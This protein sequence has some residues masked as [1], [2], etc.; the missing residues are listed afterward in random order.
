MKMTVKGAHLNNAAEMDELIAAIPHGEQLRYAL[1]KL[2]PGI[3]WGYQ[4][5]TRTGVYILTDSTW[6]VY[7]TVTDITSAQAMAVGDECNALPRWGVAEFKGAARRAVQ[8]PH[9][10]PPLGERLTIVKA[11]RDSASAMEKMRAKI[12][13]S[14]SRMM[15]DFKCGIAGDYDDELRV[16]WF[17]GA[18]FDGVTCISI[19]DLSNDEF[20]AFR[21]ELRSMEDRNNEPDWP[22][23]QVTDIAAKVLGGTYTTFLEQ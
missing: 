9:R 1:T 7:L 3:S 12:P 14:L 11:C 8:P 4:K 17:V 23:E 6:V 5:E 2:V 19:R 10:I 18:Y 16:A 21:G 13:M 20:Q 22:P 15:K